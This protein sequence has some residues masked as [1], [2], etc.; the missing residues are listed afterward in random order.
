MDCSRYQWHLSF[1]QTFSPLS[2]PVGSGKLNIGN[3]E[4][5]IITAH[6]HSWFV[7]AH[8]ILIK[9]SRGD[10]A[11]KA[12]MQRT[13]DKS[14]KSSVNLMEK[15]NKILELLFANIV[16]SLALAVTALTSNKR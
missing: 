12:M 2:V 7:D 10:R 15:Y 1:T 6:T 14:S 8:I 11:K 13:E 9:K 16:V 4:N 5:N 3:R